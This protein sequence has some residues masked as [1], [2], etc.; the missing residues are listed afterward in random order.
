MTQ[1]V[2]DSSDD[3]SKGLKKK[4]LAYILA[5]TFLVTGDLVSVMSGAE[6][7]ETSQIETY[8]VEDTHSQPIEVRAQIDQVFALEVDGQLEVVTV[9]PQW[10]E[11]N[12]LATVD[13]DWE[14][15]KKLA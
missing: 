6:G 15:V 10:D 8:Q 14:E 4:V 9:D 7:G 1:Q 2:V 5:S 3:D 12:R 11:M 13:P